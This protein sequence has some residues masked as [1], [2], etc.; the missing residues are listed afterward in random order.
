VFNEPKWGCPF[1]IVLGHPEYYPR[2]GFEL[3][4]GYGIRSDGEVPDEAF[5]AEVPDGP[6][7]RGR[8]GIAKYRPKFT[9]TM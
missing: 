4:S 2:F 7:M 6:T 5:L 9:E 8:S 3:A 1:V